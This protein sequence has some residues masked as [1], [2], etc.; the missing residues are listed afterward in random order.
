MKPLKMITGL[1]IILLLVNLNFVFAQDPIA[2]YSFDA[3]ASD[4]TGN[5]NGTLEKDAAIVNDG[6]RGTVLGLSDSGYV[7]IPAA[8]ADSMNSFSFAGWVKFNGTVNWAGLVG[9]GQDTAKGYPYFD[10]HLR[11]SGGMSFYST[12]YQVWPSDGCSK[13][14]D[15]Y[16]VPKGEWVH[17]AFSFTVNDTAIVYV[18]GQAVSTVSWKTIQEFDVAPDSLN[19][20]SVTIGR[21][22]FNQ[23]TLTNTKIDNFKFYNIA[24]T[25]GDVAD[26]YNAE[27]IEV[28]P[29]ASYSFDSDASDATGSYNGTLQ[30]DAAIV[31]DGLRG[32]VL[33]LADSGFVSVPPAI[34]SEMDDFS[35]CG[36]VKFNG[37]NPWSAL[38]GMGSDTLGVHPYFDFHLKNDGS[39]RY[40]ASVDGTWPPDGCS[41]IVDGYNVPVKEWTHIAFSFTKN[42]TGL[43][44][45]DGVEQATVP[46]KDIQEFDVSP[47]ML[48]AQL[49][50]I[51]KD[52]FNQQTLTNTKIDN[53]KFFKTDISAEKVA[54][55]YNDELITVEDFLV[56]HWKFDETSG[57]TANDE[58]A[59][60]D[61][62][63]V[64]MGDSPWV[65]G[66]DGNAIDFSNKPDTGYVEVANIATV[67]MD[68]T[69]S[70]TISFLVKADPV[71][72]TAAQNLI[73]KGTFDSSIEGHDGKRYQF[74]MKNSMLRFSVDDDVV[75]S[76]LDVVVTDFY[77]VNEWAHVVGVRDLAQDLLYLY[78][79]G[80]LIGS[81]ADGTDMDISNN[82]SLVIGSSFDGS[83]KL[84]GQMDDLRMYNYALNADKVKALY[85]SYDIPVGINGEQGVKPMTYELMQNYPNPFNPST[86]IQYQVP[87]DGLVTIS[88]YNTLGQ[89]VTTLV[90]KNMK[91][92]IHQVTFDA[93]KFSSGIYF[94]RLKAKGFSKVKKMMLLK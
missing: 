83:G 62:T 53:F 90:N 21:D 20:K 51:G 48:A 84:D 58:I 68:S 2:D 89:R 93:A 76:S 56:A 17:I 11:S 4:A 5:F 66:W 34:A 24:I 86:T 10:Y 37:T 46:W 78:L 32:Q 36:W 39:I 31:N 47:S 57:T 79:N 73:L 1:I 50:N 15:G 59:S 6:V 38:V 91:T 94:Y 9:M 19:A 70:F 72:N 18:N 42:D 60:S 49:V 63:L 61:A 88:V 77:P 43:V 26:I 67:D 29:I 44:Y 82:R 81:L 65:A 85:D 80:E 13:T 16:T 27:L 69:E 22:A 28:E 7:S 71:G 54:E 35:F 23:G 33:G 3:D 87:K 30:G 45:I 64:N 92:G 8:L 75:K 55:I 14:I 52:A 25:A 74:E 12:K 41:Q 40:Y